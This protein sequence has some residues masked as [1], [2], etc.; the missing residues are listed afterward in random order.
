LLDDPSTTTWAAELLRDDET[1]RWVRHMDALA[2][3][4]HPEVQPYVH[5]ILGHLGEAIRAARTPTN[6]TWSGATG[7]SLRD[8]VVAATE[9]PAPLIPVLADDLRAILEDR[10]IREALPELL[11]RLH[12]A[13]HLQA[14]G[15]QISWMSRVDRDGRSLQDN[16]ISALA[17][18]LRLLHDINRPLSCSFDLWVT[19]LDVQLGNIAVPLLGFLAEQDP[20]FVTG[21]SSLLTEVLGFGITD[22]I[23]DEIT[24]SGVCPV[25][26]PRLVA[27]LGALQVLQEPEAYD[28]LVVFI[29][30]LRLLEDGQESR[31]DRLADLVTDLVDMRAVDPLQEVLRD[32]GPEPLLADVVELVPALISPEDHGIALVEGGPV[33]LDDVIDVVVWLVRHQT[34]IGGIGWER[35]EPLMVPLADEPALWSSLHAFSNLMH[36][37]ESQTRQLLTWL[38]RVLAL[39]PELETLDLLATLI[40]DPQI[41][42]PLLRAIEEGTLVAELTTPRPTGQD[43]RTPL[44]FLSTL[45]VDGTLDELLSLV[46]I[47][48]STLDATTAQS[49]PPETP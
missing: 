20:S 11:T 21:T 9:G 27:D 47:T 19:D 16:E 22:T 40:D 17:A 13:G 4:N 7:D 37:E 41:A 31:L 8:V 24:S 15:P 18:F 10:Q 49:P 14:L 34:S 45:I 48:L 39:D 35:L 2:S 5:G 1:K 26:T 23:L 43:L 46:D 29:E 12:G 42:P 38:P 25:I 33:T 3:A 32:L 6:D 44:A 30:L 28:L 36:H